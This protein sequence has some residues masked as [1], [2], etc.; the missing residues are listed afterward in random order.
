MKM[1]GEN[2]NLGQRFGLEGL[3]IFSGR[4][5]KYISM[6]RVTPSDSYS[7][8]EKDQTKKSVAATV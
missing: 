5:K 4:T 7:S 2:R 3:S 8:D 6:I 1:P